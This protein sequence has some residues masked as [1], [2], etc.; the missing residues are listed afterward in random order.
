[1]NFFVELGIRM[2]GFLVNYVLLLPYMLVF[3]VGHTLSLPYLSRFLLV[4]LVRFDF[5]HT[6]CRYLLLTS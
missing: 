5:L 3:L 4:E 2:L 1:M 6:H